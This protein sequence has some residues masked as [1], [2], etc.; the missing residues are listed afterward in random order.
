MDPG[1]R[2]DDEG[3][4]GDDGYG[5]NLSAF[6]SQI[7]DSSCLAQHC[8]NKNRDSCRGDR[9]DKIHNVIVYPA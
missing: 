4:R 2:R 6:V 5:D 3:I 8:G 9:R 1:F 7:M